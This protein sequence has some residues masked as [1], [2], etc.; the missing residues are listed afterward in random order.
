MCLSLLCVN[1]GPGNVKQKHMRLVHVQSIS[2]V[3]LADRPFRT[4]H[5]F[6][7]SMRTMMLRKGAISGVSNPGEFQTIQGAHFMVWRLIFWML[8][9]KRNKKRGENWECDL[10]MDSVRCQNQ[11]F[12]WIFIKRPYPLFSRP[13]CSE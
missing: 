9:Y 12:S 13:V 4:K 8:S 10:T 1:N 5:F 3:V 2:I 7:L 11:Q 6:E